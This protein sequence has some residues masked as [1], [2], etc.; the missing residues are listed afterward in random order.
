MFSTCCKFA[1]FVNIW[2]NLKFSRWCGASLCS[3]LKLGNCCR[4]SAAG[5]NPKYQQISISYFLSLKS[6]IWSMKIHRVPTKFKKKVAL[7]NCVFWSSI[8]LHLYTQN[9]HS[10]ANQHQ[11]VWKG[12]LLNRAGGC[13][14]IYCK[15]LPVHLPEADC[16]I[17]TLSS[18]VVVVTFCHH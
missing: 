2:C 13:S 1:T 17:F 12:V 15:T 5:T 16:S 10:M 6:K 4:L 8:I 9:S 14:S 7:K 3:N 11:T 18:V